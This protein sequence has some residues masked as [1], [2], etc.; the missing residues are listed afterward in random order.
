[1]VNFR[2]AHDVALIELLGSRVIPQIRKI[3]A[4]TPL[5]A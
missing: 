3:D 1:M 2:D 4:R 5:Q